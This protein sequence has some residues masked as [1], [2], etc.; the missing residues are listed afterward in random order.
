MSV[1]ILCWLCLCFKDKHIPSK[2]SWKDVCLKVQQN[3]LIRQVKYS[4]VKL[5]MHLKVGELAIIE[6]YLLQKEYQQHSTDLD[7]PIIT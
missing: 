1:A 4:L 5:Y 2:H 7:T 6:I 3:W